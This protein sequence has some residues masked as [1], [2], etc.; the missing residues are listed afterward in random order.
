MQV[1]VAVVG[2]DVW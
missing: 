2:K 1:P